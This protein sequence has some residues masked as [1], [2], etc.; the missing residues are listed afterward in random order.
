MK[1]S[2]VKLSGLLVYIVSTTIL[3]G[4]YGILHNQITFTISNEYFTHFKFLQ[5]HLPEYYTAP[6]RLGACIIG[7]NSTWWIGLIFGFVL[8]ILCLGKNSLTYRER[9]KA[10]R[11]V[12]VT[13]FL[14]GIFGAI[15]AFTQWQQEKYYEVLNFPSYGELIDNSLQTMSNPFAFLRAETIHNFSY[16]GS[17]IGLLIGAFQ[18]WKKSAN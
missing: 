4:L 1:R 13:T 3:S 16:I 9:F 10:L 5:H 15:L 12:F 11:T 8:G 6:A 14:F 7:W 17:V 2:L 18:L